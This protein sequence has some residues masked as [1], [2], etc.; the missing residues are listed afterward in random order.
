VKQKL[1]AAGACCYFSDA[2]FGDDDDQALNEAEAY[3]IE[4]KKHAEA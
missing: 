4:M 1:Q 3:E 2:E